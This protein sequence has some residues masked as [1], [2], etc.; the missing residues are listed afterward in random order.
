MNPKKWVA[1]FYP[2]HAN[3][4]GKIE[5]AR[6][7]LCK[8]EGS[9]L[10]KFVVYWVQVYTEYNKLQRASMSILPLRERNRQKV[11]ERIIA[12]AMELFK[13]QGCQQTTMDDIAI[14]AE[15]SRGTLFNYFPS[16][17]ALLLPWGQEILEEYVKPKLAEYLETGPKTIDVLHFLFANMSENVRAAPDLIRAFVG[18]ALKAT[19]K[20]HADRTRTGMVEV[21]TQVLTYGQSR[22]D[23]RADLSAEEMAGYMSALQT[24]LL[25]HLLS[26]PTADSS[27]VTARLLMFIEAGLKAP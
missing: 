27:Q 22:G 26:E 6:E 12:A 15:I 24:G 21:F 10:T 1:L 19:N 11:T 4:L 18:E 23:V 16:K 13:A 9:I 17:D 25:F 20:P 3:E 14:K 7:F 2:L 8:K 5:I